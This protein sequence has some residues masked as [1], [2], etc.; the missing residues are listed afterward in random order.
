MRV[1]DGVS[2]GDEAAAQAEYGR[3]VIELA[4]D[5]V[6][7]VYLRVTGVLGLAA[8][9]LTQLPFKDLAEMSLW[10]RWAFVLGLVAAGAS[11]GFYFRYLSKLH[12]A[13]LKMARYVRY[14][15]GGSVREIWAGDGIFWTE[16]SY[17]FTLGT[18]LAFVSLAMLGV[19]LG[20]LLNL[21]P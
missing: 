18:C 15:S 7:Q 4:G 1:V 21:V 8:L 16:H 12:L 5:D 19:V 2:D 14:G 13:R 6:R 20:E 10:A 17:L 9:F 3:A 11:A